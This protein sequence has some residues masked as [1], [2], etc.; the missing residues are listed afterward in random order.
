MT[1]HTPGP[2]GATTRQRSWD[3]VVFQASDPNTEICQMFHDG[4]DENLTGE[5]NAR[6]I[7]AAPETAAERDR[8]REIN[9][10]LVEALEAHRAWSYAEEHNLGTFEA[11]SV[12]CAHANSLTLAAL[13][14]AK[15]EKPP[16]YQG[17]KRLVIWPSLELQ[18]SEIEGARA[19]V[20][21]ILEHE[22]AA[23]AKVEGESA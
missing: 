14:K 1:E 16:E 2:W 7:A 13:A 3:W 4:T 11:K 15:G 10:E 17:H 20:A 22:R 6:L 21:E 23:I 8:L 9:A 12:L 18:E 19:F 5:A